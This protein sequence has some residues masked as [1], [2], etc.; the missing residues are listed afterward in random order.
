MSEISKVLLLV[1]SPKGENS[2]SNNIA[3]YILEKFNENGVKAEKIFIVKEVRNDE[4]LNELVLQ[5]IDAEI[6]ILVSPLY[7]DSIP[8]INIKVLEEFYKVKNDSFSKKQRFMTIFNCGF[9]EPH[10]NDLAMD[11]C[12]KFAS[13]TGLEWIG[14]VTIGMGPSLEGKSLESF[15]MA[16]NLCTGLDMAVDAILKGETVPQEAIVIASKPLMPLT[17]V[18]FVMCNFGRFMWGNQMDKSVK[19][20]MFD[21]PYEL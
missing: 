16:K 18:K 6:L 21:R 14:G 15:R 11:M 7:V 4:A 17:I 12:K 2:V 8:A 3:S 20:N 19:G 5:A 10:H 9:P 1:G 13:D